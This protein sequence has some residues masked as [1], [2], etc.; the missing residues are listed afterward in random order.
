MEKEI[1][2]GHGVKK[3][4]MSAFKCTYPTIR[5]ALRYKTDTVLS[6]KIRMAAISRGG[7]L[8]ESMKN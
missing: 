8:V 7:R 2:I 5:T 4:I 3:E 1:L 6:S